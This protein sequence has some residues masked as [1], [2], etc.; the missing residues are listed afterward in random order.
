MLSRAT[1]ATEKR[2]LVNA[3]SWLLRSLKSYIG[4]LLRVTQHAPEGL[5]RGGYGGRQGGVVILKKSDDFH[6]QQLE[7][8][9]QLGE[10]YPRPATV[11]VLELRQQVI[12]LILQ[13][14]L[15]EQADGV[16]ISQPLF[17][18]GQIQRGGCPGGGGRSR[19]SGRR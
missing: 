17:E 6:Q 4:E 13:R 16:S 2:E 12:D 18:R 10:R 15:G 3:G 19:S 9:S 8:L 5:A 11:K 1:S 14:E 7:F